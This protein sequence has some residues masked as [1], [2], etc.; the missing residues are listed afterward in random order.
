MVHALKTIFINRHQEIQ[1]SPLCAEV[2][3]KSGRNSELNIL[4]LQNLI[5]I[6]RGL[7][8]FA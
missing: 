8:L 2:Q 7:L 1:K 5:H 4:A 3:A 6:L